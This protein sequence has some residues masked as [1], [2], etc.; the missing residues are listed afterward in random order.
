MSDKEVM[1]LITRENLFEICEWS[2]V[3]MGL[4]DSNYILLTVPAIK[5]QRAADLEVLEA[6]IKWMEN[7]WRNYTE[8]KEKE[9]DAERKHLA[10]EELKTLK[11]TLQKEAD[12]LEK[13]HE[14]S[15]EMTG[16]THGT[17]E[18]HIAKLRQEE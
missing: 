12:W 17:I 4:T 9:W 16:I 11:A 10:K 13:W 3:D 8:V 18:R 5:A 7:A 14:R 2:L 6:E 1:P 15:I